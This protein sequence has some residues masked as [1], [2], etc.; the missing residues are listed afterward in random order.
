M[1]V[2]CRPLHHKIHF[3]KIRNMQISWL[4]HIFCE[5]FSLPK[6]A[7]R[8]CCFGWKLFSLIICYL[9]IVESYAQRHDDVPFSDILLKC[10]WSSQ[11][12]SFSLYAIHAYMHGILGSRAQTLNQYQLEIYSVWVFQWW[13]QLPQSR[14]IYYLLRCFSIHF[15]LC[16]WK[17]RSANVTKRKVS[18]T[19]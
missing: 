1:T 2:V 7:E 11:R 14:I 15:R 3:A 5:F 4:A 18:A 9:S 17:R 10:R 8:I 13:K 12:K 16:S 19:L 6:H